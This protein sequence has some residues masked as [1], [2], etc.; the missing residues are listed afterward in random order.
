MSSC[1]CFIKR[2]EFSA[3]T[4]SPQEIKCLYLKELTSAK[5]GDISASNSSITESLN[6]GNSS[7]TLTLND[8]LHC[9]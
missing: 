9:L 6:F 1:N 3:K 4:P 7:L 2:S 5:N 8:S